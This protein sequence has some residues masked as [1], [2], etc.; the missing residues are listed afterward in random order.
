MNCGGWI[1]S[2]RSTAMAL[3]A[4]GAASPAPLTQIAPGASTARIARRDTSLRIAS[5]PIETAVKNSESRA[6]LQAKKATSAA[7]RKAPE[8]RSEFADLR[9]RPRQRAG[10]F[11]LVADRPQRSVGGAHLYGDAGE[12]IEHRWPHPG[13]TRAGK[14]LRP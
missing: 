2:R 10:L 12:R 8:R 9:H 13:E 14:G 1:S 6:S 11:D 5:L 3:G 4:S 7:H